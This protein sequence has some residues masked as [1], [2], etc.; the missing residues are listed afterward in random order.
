ME[1]CIIFKNLWYS[2]AC[3]LISNNDS[4]ALLSLFTELMLACFNVGS[5][6]V[7]LK[8]CATWVHVFGP[9]LCLASCHSHTLHLSSRALYGTVNNT[10]MKSRCGWKV[11]ERIKKGN[12][13]CWGLERKNTSQ[14]AKCLKL[15]TRRGLWEIRGLSWGVEEQTFHITNTS[16][17][18][19]NETLLPS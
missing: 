12:R 3:K 2:T 14:S 7:W 8:R 15:I 11:H 4:N 9:V 16:Y 19:S 1:L 13:L 17:A 18:F 6:V 10:Q 5:N